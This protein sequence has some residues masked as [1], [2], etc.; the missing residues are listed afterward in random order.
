MNRLRLS[1][2]F[3]LLS[4][5]MAAALAAS[6]APA[7]SGPADAAP[8][9]AF[10]LPDTTVHVL[11]APALHRD[12]EVDVA[13]PASYATSPERKY[14]VV[15]V[16]DAP[17]GFPVTQA[18]AGRITRHSHEM[19]EFILVGLGYARGDEAQASR[20][21]DYTPVQPSP[22]DMPNANPSGKPAVFGES[23][24]YRRFLADV[25]KPFLASHYRVDPSRAVLAG[26]SYGGLFAADVLAN[27]PG[28]FSGYVLGSP[29]LWFGDRLFITREGTA[30]KSSDDP[31]A[32]RHAAVYLGVGGYEAIAPKKAAD[33][34][35]Y[36]EDTDMVADMK[37]YAAA[38]KAHGGDGLRL[39]SEVIDGED[40]LTV[41]PI[42]LT[43]G[44]MFV[45]GQ[46]GNGG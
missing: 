20:R 33:R 13:L 14:P 12:Y 36:N 23:A 17:Y 11:H 44:L 1:A 9:S 24:A 45:L 26:H 3:A 22:R 32:H 39:K 21:R 30:P 37:T 42:L 41:G 18:I 35:R 7:A 4:A 31:R 34:R 27:E 46:S 40:H 6:P 43:H 19:P 15:Y 28:L 2:A 10:V 8:V 38:L 25:V 29:S 5:C 16:L